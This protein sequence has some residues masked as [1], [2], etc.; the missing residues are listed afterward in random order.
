MQSVSTRQNEPDRSQGEGT[1]SST[2]WRILAAAEEIMSE[3]GLMASSIA[4]IARKAGVTDSV[5]YQY[6][7]GKQDLLFSIP[8]ER[9]K[10]VLALVEEQLTGIQDVDSRLRKLVWFH[11][12]YNDAHRSYA[13]LLLLECRSSKDFYS[14]P[15]YA[16]VRTY[17]AILL[18]TLEQGVE[19]GKIRQDVDVRLIRDVILGTLDM[20]NIGSLASGELK[21]SED[22]FEAIMMLVN[23][24]IA[25]RIS[26]DDTKRD[27]RHEILIAAE[28]VFSEKDFNKA[29]VA[30]IAKSVGVADGTIYEYFESKED[31]LFSIAVSRFDS[32]LSE[33]SEA[34]EIRHP[35]RKLRRLIKFHFASFL[36][37]PRFLK[38]FLLQLQLNQRF[39]GS[40]A[41][42]RF[43]RYFGRI[44]EVV[45]EGKAAGVFDSTAN[46][47]VFRNMFL[48][49]FS[50]MALRWLILKESTH[51]DR[52]EEINQATDLLIS[53]VTG[54]VD[55]EG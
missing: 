26:P 17:A 16:L 45:E 47:R 2:K 41:F 32:Y 54:S 7:K 37:E 38:V 1:T 53:A 24:M 13:R 20:E 42:D 35:V 46:S 43:R 27:R 49:A 40:T 5:I 28:K 48:G 4:E 55:R 33:V 25:A 14:T 44:E 52:M 18:S 10:E 39:Y 31:I 12:R 34:F 15:A 50:H 9:M 3:K 22:D 8:A 51:T 23:C 30:E 29:T 11:L 36:T 6:F 19:Q 21:N